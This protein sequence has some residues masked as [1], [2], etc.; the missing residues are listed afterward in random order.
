[1]KAFSTRLTELRHFVSKYRPEAGDWEHFGVPGLSEVILAEDN[2]T[3]GHMMPE[4]EPRERHAVW[5]VLTLREHDYP[6]C[7]CD[8]G[9]YH[10]C[11]W[12]VVDFRD[13][14]FGPYGTAGEAAIAAREHAAEH[15]LF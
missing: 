7:H 2:V 14:H 5:W 12:D 3:Y 15:G 10:Y 11:E 13:E 1:M 8:E 4:G 6:I 9:L